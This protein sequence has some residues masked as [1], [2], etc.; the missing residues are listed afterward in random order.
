MTA[1]YD[2]LCDEGKL[3]ADRLKAAG[4]TVEYHCVAGQIHG[5]CSFAD[6]IPQGREVLVGL[7]GVDL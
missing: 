6:H 2:P 1:E 5:F 7:F 4:N 3:Y